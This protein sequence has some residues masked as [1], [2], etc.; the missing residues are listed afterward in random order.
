LPVFSSVV[1]LPCDRWTALE[2]V[3]K[4]FSKLCPSSSLVNRDGETKELDSLDLVMGDV[5]ILK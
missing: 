1:C 2:Q 4:S 3:L 5:V